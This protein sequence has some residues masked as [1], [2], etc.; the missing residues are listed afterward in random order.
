MNE[1][2]PIEMERKRREL[3]PVRKFINKIDKYQGKCSIRGD[4][5]VVDGVTYT[6]DELSK[7]PSD[8]NLESLY[9][10]TEDGVT[11][12]FRKG[13][14][15]SNHYPAP[16]NLGGVRFACSEQYYFAKMADT[17]KDEDVL[18]RVMGTSDPGLMVDASKA[19]KRRTKDWKA[20]ERQ[21]MKEGVQAKVDQN[22]VVRD[23]LKSTGA[24]RIAEASPN[25]KTW[26]IG[27]SMTDKGRHNQNAWGDNILGDILQEIRSTL[28]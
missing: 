16:F 15:L 25:D 3:Y 2:Y 11:F 26:G 7:L 8:I 13:G 1:H 19:I 6:T 12:F 23:F 27:M 10:K 21:T 14:P 5:L 28:N 24:T 18:A 22:K 20:I 17:C 9:T 4:R